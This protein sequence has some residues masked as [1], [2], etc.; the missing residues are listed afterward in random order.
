MPHNHGHFKPFGVL[1]WAAPYQVPC[2]DC[3]DLTQPDANSSRGLRGATFDTGATRSS[4]RFADGP[5][6]LLYNF[7]F[8]CARAP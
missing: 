8:R 7:G 3:A 5:S 6:D 4:S 1:D 2:V